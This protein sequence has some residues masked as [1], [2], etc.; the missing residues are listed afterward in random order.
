MTTEFC[1][2]FLIMAFMLL[3]LSQMCQAFP[4]PEGVKVEKVTELGFGFQVVIL[5]IPNSWEIGHHAFLFYR[6]EEICSLGKCSVSPSGSYVIYQEGPS[7]N[8]FLYRRADARKVQLKRFAPGSVPI[9]VKFTWHEEAGTVDWVY[10]GEYV[11][12][13]EVMYPEESKAP[14]PCDGHGER[15]DW[16]SAPSR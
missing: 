3:A 11:R 4:V 5:A 2:R 1:K 9:V 13:E 7:G 12:I 16:F 14:I 15:K 6:D 10:D 8:I